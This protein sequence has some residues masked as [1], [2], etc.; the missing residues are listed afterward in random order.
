MPRKS[1]SSVAPNHK[2]FHSSRKTATTHSKVPIEQATAG[3][4]YRV[5]D[6]NWTKVWG[7]NLS[8]ADANTLL[9]TVVGALQS[10]TARVEDMDIGR[11]GAKTG[12][13]PTIDEV[14]EMTAT[15]DSLGVANKVHLDPEA[16]S[17]GGLT[18]DLHDL[19][20]ELGSEPS[21]DD[22]EHAMRQSDAEPQILR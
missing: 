22:F 20:A 19:L 13:P 12:T 21:D 6:K 1:G 14:L 3:K 17:N 15:D 10:R 8:W 18:P 2:P 16:A 9:N 11:P 4:L 5:R 7:E